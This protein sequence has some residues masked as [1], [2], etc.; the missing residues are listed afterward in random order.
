MSWRASSIEVGSIRD[1]NPNNDS[2]LFLREDLVLM[3]SSFFPI[4]TSSGCAE[5]ILGNL[6]YED[7]SQILKLSR[8][9][10]IGG[11]SE[12]SSDSSEF[13][14]RTSVLAEF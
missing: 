7:S 4:I 6:F 3:G 8:A 2:S 11:S 9:L 14:N 10:S 12:F 13:V 5:V 1:T